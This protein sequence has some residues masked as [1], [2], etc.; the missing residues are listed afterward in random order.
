MPLARKIGKRPTYLLSI[1]CL[2][3]FNAWS[4]VASSYTSLLASQLVGVFMVAAADAPV[5]GVVVDLFF[6][7]EGGH[8]LMLFHFSIAAGAFDGPFINAYVTQYAGWRWMCGLMTVAGRYAPPGH[9][10]DPGDC[11]RY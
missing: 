4:W 1:L 10:S 3:V 5:P 2:C 6:Y 7:H 9:A 11:P 8:A